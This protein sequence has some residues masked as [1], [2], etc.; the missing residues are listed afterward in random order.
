[1]RAGLLRGVQKV[2][3]IL[4]TVPSPAP[5]YQTQGP[6]LCTQLPILK[7]DRSRTVRLA[8]VNIIAKELGPFCRDIENNTGAD[9]KR[10]AGQTAFAPQLF[11][12]SSTTEARAL[13]P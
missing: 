3:C 8:C 4:Q 1:M 11:N 2:T 5:F 9:R 13:R 7:A 12:R 6:L 10:R